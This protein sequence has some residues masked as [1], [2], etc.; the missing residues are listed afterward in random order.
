MK[1]IIIAIAVAILTFTGANNANAQNDNDRDAR[2]QEMQA[3]QTERLIKDLKLT[4]EQKEKFEP[5]YKRYL[6]ELASARQS[7]TRDQRADDE[8]KELTDEQAT[9]RVQEIFARQEQQIQQSQLRL[10]IQRKYCAEFS[11]VLTPQQLVRVFTPQMGR[12]NQRQGSRGGFG[13]GQRGGF[14]GAPRGGF[15]GGD[16]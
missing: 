4:D 1:K 8:K 2:R 7:E 12:G 3:R 9:A 16:F 14:G 10:D 15:G 11:A 6:T 5:I 13:G